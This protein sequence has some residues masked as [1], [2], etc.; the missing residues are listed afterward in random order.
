MSDLGADRE[1]N[2]HISHPDSSSPRVSESQ[3]H[4]SKRKIQVG[5]WQSATWGAATP[6]CIVRPG[7][8]H[9]PPSPTSAKTRRTVRSDYL[10]V[11][12]VSDSPF[13]SD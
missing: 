12:T 4:N 9:P 8:L 6:T 1:V 11:I 7:V 13:V 10:G 3:Q 5:R 2:A